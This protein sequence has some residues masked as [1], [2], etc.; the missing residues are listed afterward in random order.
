LSTS[1][2]VSLIKFVLPLSLRIFLNWSLFSLL[3]VLDHRLLSPY[4]DHLLPHFSELQTVLFN[5]RHPTFGINSLAHSF[6]EP[7]PHPGLS[8]SHY[9]H[10][11]AGLFFFC[12][13][14]LFQ[15]LQR[16]RIACNTE[17]CNT[18]SNSVCPSVRLFVRP[19]HAGTL[20]R[21]M[22][23]GLRGLHCELAKTL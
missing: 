11:S 17:R 9:L 7:H 16:G 3:A 10:K 18:Y 8:P 4:P 6:R 1:F 19:S 5:M 14:V 23:I 2:S 22:N 13:S 12:S 15:F 20:S 21:R